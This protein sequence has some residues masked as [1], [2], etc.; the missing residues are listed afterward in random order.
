MRVSYSARSPP[1]TGSSASTARW[2]PPASCHPPARVKPELVATRP[3]QVYSWDITKL[4]ART[5]GRTSTCTRSST[6]TAATWSG[7][8]LARAERAELCRGLMAETIAKQGSGPQLT[9]HSDRGHR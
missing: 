7:W 3:N 9:I 1:C 8:M 6:S 2:R 4:L 5:S